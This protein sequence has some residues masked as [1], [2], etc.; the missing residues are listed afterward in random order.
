MTIPGP[1]AGLSDTNKLAIETG[2]QPTEGWSGRIA[3]VVSSI[4]LAFSAW[5]LWETSLRAPDLR[6][7]IPPV[8]HYA[9]PYNNS[10]FEMVSIP[11]T[12]INDGARTGTVLSMEL[13]VTDPR[14]Q[15]T[16]RFY[17]AD[18]GR[19]SMERTRSQAYAHFAPFAMAG[20]ASKT[21]TILF[22]TRG[23]AEKP[24]QLIKEVGVYQFRLKFDVAEVDDFGWLDRVWKRTEP[25][26]TFERSLRFYD[27]RSFQ[28]GTIPMDAKDWKMGK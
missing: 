27:A 20:R 8:I 14:T 22:Y 9:A 28:T 24:E 17:A 13:E 23:E 25:T 12:V 26:L 6:V 4:A 7:F 15:Q 5:S 11:I 3:A 10:N 19:W 1:H 2:N 16:K 21:E 18:M